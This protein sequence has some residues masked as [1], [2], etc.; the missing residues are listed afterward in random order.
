MS[1]KTIGIIVIVVGLLLLVVA[2]AADSLG[3]G[4]GNG[5]GWKQIVGALVGLVIAAGGAWWGW[6]KKTA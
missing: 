3:I 1:R 6:L 5:I 4:G 2:L